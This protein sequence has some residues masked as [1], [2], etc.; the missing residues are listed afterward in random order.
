MF[1]TIISKANE[2]ARQA[3]NIAIVHANT[4]EKKILSVKFDCSWSHSR[5]AGQ[6]SGEFIYLDDL[7]GKL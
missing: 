5:N 7:K 3:L 6:A 4:K 2:S 1:S